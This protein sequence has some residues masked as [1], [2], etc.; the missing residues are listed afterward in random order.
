MLSTGDLHEVAAHAKRFEE[1]GFDGLWTIEAQ[2]D[3]FLPLAVASTATSRVNLGTPI[4]VACP[5]SRMTPAYTAWDLAA[6]SKG[7]FIL[8]LGTQVKG[9]N[10]R[11]F[12]V[13][14]EQPVKKLREVI[15]SLRA[16]W[17]SWQTGAKLDFQGEFYRFTLMTP[18]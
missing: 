11:R 15:L 7:R 12:S 5:R 16:I 3:P 1:I 4:A 9:H 8:G 18:F 14:W 17:N 10:E 6:S 2:H 13:K